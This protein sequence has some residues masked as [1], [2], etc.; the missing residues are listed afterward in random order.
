MKKLVIGLDQSY[1]DTGLCLAVDGIPKYVESVNFCGLN[2]KADKR[3][4]VV[5]RLEAV[6]ERYKGKYFIEIVIEAI[7]LFSGS[8]PHISTAYIYSTCALIGAIVDFASEN[9]IDVYW[10]DTRSWKK[11]VL[12]SSKPSGKKLNGVKDKNKVDSVLYAISIGFGKRIS[13]FVKSGKN[14]GKIRYNDNMADAICIAIAGFNK[15]I[16]KK[17]DN[18]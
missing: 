13:Y 4:A 1:T 17:V 7:R 5:S 15:N 14:K 16:S 11:F 3:R 9:G 6:F 10:V 2:S 18:F 12:G 8:Q